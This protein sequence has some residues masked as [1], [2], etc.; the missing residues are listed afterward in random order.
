MEAPIDEPEVA[1]IS[2]TYRRF[3][4]TEARGRSALY[5]A[6]ARGIA[7][8]RETISFLLTLPSEKRQ[9]NLLLAAV[10]HL[11]ATPADWNDFR[12]KLSADPDAVRS[13]M[14]A[15]ST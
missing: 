9:P 7:G 5:E 10:R 8:D 15:R 14:L 11:R 1:L 13:L 2:A 6:L 12:R 3:A 4:D